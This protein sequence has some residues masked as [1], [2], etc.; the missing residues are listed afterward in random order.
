[1]NSG[2]K[3]SKLRQILEEEQKRR[4]KI[5]RKERDRSLSSKVEHTSKYWRGIIVIIVI[6]SSLAKKIGDLAMG[7]SKACSN[8]ES[9]ENINYGRN[10]Y[11]YES[12]GHLARNCRNKR[13]IE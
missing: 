10:C 5:E 6:V 12:F 8:K 11:S 2:I 3:N 9:R 4:E 13:I 1:L 7:T